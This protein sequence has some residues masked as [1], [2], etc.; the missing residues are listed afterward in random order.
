MVEPPP[1]AVLGEVE[2]EVDPEVDG[3]LAP[4]ALELLVPLAP[5]CVAVLVP[6]ALVV[7]AELGLGELD[8]GHGLWVEVAAGT[9][10]AAGVATGAPADV[11]PAAPAPEA[12]VVEQLPELE[13]FSDPS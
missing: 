13:V 6:P 8:A 10:L 12:A 4:A 3:L 2:L 7:V 9:P 11:V 5:L 1:D